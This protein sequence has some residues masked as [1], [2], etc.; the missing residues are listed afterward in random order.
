MNTKVTNNI[1]KANGTSLIGYLTSTYSALCE[2]LGEPLR[3]HSGDGKVTCEWIIEFE[4]GS[5]GTIYDWKMKA[6]PLNE[7]NWHVGGRGINTLDKVSKFVKLP[8]CRTL[9]A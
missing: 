3:D 9:F 4:D 6:T 7:Y 1:A 2:K 8:A 5:V